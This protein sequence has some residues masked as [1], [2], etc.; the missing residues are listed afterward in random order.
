APGCAVQALPGINPHIFT[1][2]WTGTPNPTPPARYDVQYLDSGRGVW[3]D[4]LGGVPATT[5]TFTGQI[6]HRYSFRCRAQDDA[7]SLGAYPVSGDTE[8]LVGSQTDLPDLHVI[9]LAA[10]TDP[11]GGVQ[12][13][14]TVRND[15]AAMRRGFF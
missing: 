9:S 4:W 13:R 14:L 15:G 7:G 2:A 3:R 1:V 6:G 12:A 8:T 10:A 11:G 5:A